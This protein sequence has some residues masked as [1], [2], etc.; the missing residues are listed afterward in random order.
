MLQGTEVN[1]VN[2]PETTAT[3][4]SENR[5]EILAPKTGNLRY[6][7]TAKDVI[8]KGQ[9]ICRVDGKAVNAPEAGE[10]VKLID[11]DTDIEANDIIAYIRLTS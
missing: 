7:F 11:E 1:K 8:R 3:M 5:I 4:I 10:L 9:A 2:T 6:A